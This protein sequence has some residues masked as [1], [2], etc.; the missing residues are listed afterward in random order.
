[1]ASV[2]DEHGN[3]V[4]NK[5]LRKGNAIPLEELQ[6][7]GDMSRLFASE[8]VYD[9]LTPQAKEDLAK[10]GVGKDQF[11]HFLGGNPE[12]DLH[13]NLDQTKQVEGYN[14]VAWWGLK[15]E[16]KASNVTELIDALALTPENYPTG[17]VRFNISPETAFAAGVVKP[18]A[19]DGMFPEWEATLGTN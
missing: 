8:K 10:L 5:Y 3:V 19:L 13:G 17:G 12:Y 6:K 9:M 16:G 11:G 2:K 4:E 7:A 1:A 14:N 18:T 15:S